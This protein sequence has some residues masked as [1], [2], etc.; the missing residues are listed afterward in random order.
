M[1]IKSEN[2][3]VLAVAEYYGFTTHGKFKSWLN[4]M[5]PNCKIHYRK[6][7]G[8][9]GSTRVLTIKHHYPCTE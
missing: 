5:N 3:V 7:E 2:P 9:L 4:M 1:K 8:E 6:S